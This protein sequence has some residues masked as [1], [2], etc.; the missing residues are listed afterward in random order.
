MTASEKIQTCRHIAPN[1]IEIYDGCPCK[2]KKK[3]VAK[4]EKRRI[5]GLE[6]RHCE[7]C[8]FYEAKDEP[9]Q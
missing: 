6:E 5:L 1:K 3:L 4:C 7:N 9:A 2:N 8:E